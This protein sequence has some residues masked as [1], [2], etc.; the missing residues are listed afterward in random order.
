MQC[1]S[2]V[3]ALGPANAVCYGP[4]CTALTGCFG[5]SCLLACR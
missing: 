5:E 3:M 2:M 4:A 1:R